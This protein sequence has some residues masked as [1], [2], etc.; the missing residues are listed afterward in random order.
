MYNI[1]SYSLIKFLFYTY[2]LQYYIL[3]VYAYVYKI[4][5]LDNKC[6]SD[7]DFDC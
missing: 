2:F 5:L 1:C 6:N 7:S 4:S 3:H